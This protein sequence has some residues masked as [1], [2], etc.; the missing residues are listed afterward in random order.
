[1]YIPFP[2]VSVIAGLALATGHFLVALIVKDISWQRDS[3]S[4]QALSPYPNL[5]S[6]MCFRISQILDRQHCAHS[7]CFLHPQW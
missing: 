5:G 7:E 2:I 3:L 1:M 4:L 6:Q